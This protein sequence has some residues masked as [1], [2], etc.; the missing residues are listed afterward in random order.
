[1]KTSFI[2]R[3]KV[4]VRF[5]I[6]GLGA[7][8]MDERFS[9]CVPVRKNFG[10]FGPLRLNRWSPESLEGTCARCRLPALPGLDGYPGITGKRSRRACS[11][12]N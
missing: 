2:P 10:S 9:H 4:S 1:M 8:G 7:K 3:V 6:A 11:Y 5:K 12:G